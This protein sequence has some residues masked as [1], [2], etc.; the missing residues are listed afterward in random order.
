MAK[1]L[2]RVGSASGLRSRD[3]SSALHAGSRWSLNTAAAKLLP[4]V[5]SVIA[6]SVDV[7][8]FT[9]LDGLF[10][11]HITGNLVILAARFLAGSSSPL[12]HLISVPVFIMALAMTRMLA[13]GL[14]RIG[15]VTLRPLLSL[16][17]LLLCAF[18]VI[19]IAAGPKVPPDAAI[20][21]F[22]AMLGVSA[23]AVQN[24]LVQISLA[25]A[26]S[27]AV[28]TTNVTRFALDLGQVLLHKGTSGAVE[29]VERARRT[30]LVI[31]GFLVGCGLGAWSWALLGLWSLALPTGLALLALA[32]AFAVGPPDAPARRFAR[33][34]ADRMRPSRPGCRRTTL[35]GAAAHG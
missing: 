29:A 24:A 13:D 20:M 14:D 11:A 6:G 28:M 7:I 30:G 27:T 17:F 21:I 1:E 25:D 2:S 16:Q 33:R 10:T 23:M 18:F 34:L 3:I 26:P 22:A 9:G 32:M 19:C 8:S 4:V 15:V 5:L 35:A 12:A 31:V